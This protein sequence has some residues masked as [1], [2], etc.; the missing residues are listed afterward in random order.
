[1]EKKFASSDL[2]ALENNAV[3]IEN[4]IEALKSR[5]SKAPGQVANDVLARC[6]P[7]THAD[8]IDWIRE[9]HTPANG[10]LPRRWSPR[11][12]TGVWLLYHA[13]NLEC[14]PDPPR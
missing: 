6:N 9:R 7:D 8:L 11:R 2:Y 3:A 13:A 10:R 14:P 5:L 4:A 1:M 12:D